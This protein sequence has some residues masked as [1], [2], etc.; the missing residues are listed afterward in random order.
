[1]LL[2]G[3]TVIAIVGFGRT[4]GLFMSLG[5]NSAVRVS[6]FRIAFDGLASA[7]LWYLLYRRYDVGGHLDLTRLG[8]T[9]LPV[10][11]PTV[12]AL[13]AL[14][15]LFVGSYAFAFR[16]GRGQPS[17][18][19]GGQQKMLRRSLFALDRYFVHVR[20]GG[21]SEHR[22]VDEWLVSET[23]C[24]LHFTAGTL[25]Q[26]GG[27]VPGRLSTVL[28]Q[29]HATAGLQRP[30]RMSTAGGQP[31]GTDADSSQWPRRPVGTIIVLWGLLL[32]TSPRWLPYLR[33]LTMQ[34]V[35]RGLGAGMHGLTWFPVSLI[36]TVPQQQAVSDLDVVT[37]ALACA[38]LFLRRTPLLVR[39]AMAGIALLYI[40]VPL[41]L[42]VVLPAV[43]LWAI[44]MP[45]PLCY[46]IGKLATVENVWVRADAYRGRGARGWGTLGDH[47]SLAFRMCM[48]VAIISLIATIW[49]A[50]SFGQSYKEALV[51]LLTDCIPIVVYMLGLHVL[52]LILSAR[53]ASPFDLRSPVALAWA[54]LAVATALMFAGEFLWTGQLGGSIFVS[55]PYTH[56]AAGVSLSGPVPSF[57]QAGPML[58]AAGFTIGLNKALLAPAATWHLPQVQHIEPSRA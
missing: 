20:S 50:M 51:T 30:P 22:S 34:P 9:P 3:I 26:G 16:L 29:A 38:L 54:G 36:G 33:P 19:A 35:I 10:R 11:L 17:L 40:S 14:V 56:L 27:P 39:M 7:G 43:P 42:L 53:R 31:A 5:Y 55:F 28:A 21:R 13:G 49:A 57:W 6:S 46:A 25:T 47:V 4:F 18:Q 32:W 41:Y 12:A 15:M 44:V 2:G 45:V 37:A 48:S 1:M 24:L 23:R 58:A 8:V 52:V